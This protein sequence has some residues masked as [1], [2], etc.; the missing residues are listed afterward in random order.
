[1]T[2]DYDAPAVVIGLDS[3]QGLQ[4][5]RILARH[6][7]VVHGVS[8]QAKHGNSRTRSCTTVRAATDGPAVIEALEQLGRT[9]AT[10]GVLVPCTD[11][12]VRL[13]SQNRYRLAEWYH[14]ALPDDE[15]LQT[16]MDKVLFHRYATTHGL[17]VPET[18]ILK[19][20][21]DAEE[22]AEQLS[23][24]CALK[25]AFRSPAWSANT[26]IK[27]FKVA[28]PEELLDTYDTVSDWAEL[29]LAQ[30][31]IPGGEDRLFSVNAY[32]D[33]G[34]AP[35]ASFVARKIR[36]WPPSTGQSSLGVE[37]RN[38]DVL[39]MALSMFGD[40]AYRGLAYL[41]VKQDANTGAYYIVEPN[42]GRPTGRSA[43]AEAG[44]VELLLTMYC[45]TVGAALPDQ[46]TQTYGDVKW[47][48]LRRDLQSAV[49]WWRKGDLG[50]GDWYRSVKGPKA[51][52]MWSLKDPIPFFADLARTM[53]VAASGKGRRS[54][55]LNVNHKKA[56]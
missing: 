11:A 27:A 33:R 19:S 29:L 45:D 25:P 5:A 36:Q 13:I 7:I 44:G 35:L 40:A 21:F 46:R 30:Q 55:R 16:L 6:G 17:A 3:M 52:A 23:F 38:D 53:R 20:R 1:M 10:R 26:T 2:G 9:L 41:E 28:S 24:P 48:H 18:H 37:C 39:D 15:L 56:S 54:R 14:T 4:A 22:A 43:I 31:W 12:T 50:P 47:I 42:I 32:F 51:F 49:Y 8:G 34:G